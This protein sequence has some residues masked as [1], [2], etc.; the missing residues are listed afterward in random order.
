MEE[1]LNVKIDAFILKD[2]SVHICGFQLS[3]NCFRINA[4]K[5]KKNSH[6]EI[7]HPNHMIWNSEK[8]KFKPL[9]T[10]LFRRAS[11]V[12]CHMKVPT[13]SNLRSR[14]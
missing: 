10:M 6:W 12:E 3:D 2:E 8:T 9:Q 1:L 14:V 5:K 7:K 13:M 11:Y 4:K